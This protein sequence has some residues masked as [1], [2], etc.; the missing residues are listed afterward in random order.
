MYNVINLSKQ[1]GHFAATKKTSLTVIHGAGNSEE[2]GEDSK[3]PGCHDLYLYRDSRLGTESGE[4]TS[5]IHT[6]N[7]YSLSICFEGKHACTAVHLLFLFSLKKYSSLCS[8]IMDMLGFFLA[9]NK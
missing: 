6:G 5:F 9:D 1:M 7:V 3:I 2:E 8:Q 4:N